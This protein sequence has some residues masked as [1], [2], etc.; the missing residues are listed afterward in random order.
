MATA[1]STALAA[2][3]RSWRAD[4]VL[5]VRQAL[6]ASPDGWQ[7]ATLR[8]LHRTGRASASACH[9]PGKSAT[10]AWAIWWV[11][12]C[13]SDP[14]VLTTA[15]TQHQLRDVLWSEVAKWGA[16]LPAGIRALFDVGTER[17]ALKARP[18]TWWAVARVARPEQPE[19]LAGVHADTVLVVIDEASGVHDAIWETLEG[20]LTGPRCWILAI[21]NPTRRD[22]EF[23][24]IHG[25]ADS[26]WARHRVM[27]A[28]AHDGSPLPA[29]V[30]TSE[31]VGANYEDKMR[32]RYGVESNVY[33]VRVLGLPP[34]SNDD[35]TIPT[36]WVEAAAVRPV[37]LDLDACPMIGVDVARFG[38]DDSALV[39]R[40]GTAILHVET[41]HGHDIAETTGRVVAYAKGVESRMVEREASIKRA[42]PPVLWI[43][44]DTTGLGAGVADNLRAYLNGEGKGRPW[45]VL[46]VDAGSAS[47]DDEC[48][49]LRDA[50]WW[51]TREW[52]REAAPSISPDVP[53][54]EREQLVA[55]LGAPTYKFTPAG[56]VHVEPKEK[57][58]DRGVASPNAADAL[59]HTFKVDARQPERRKPGTWRDKQAPRKGATWEWGTA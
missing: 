53:Q 51:R 52:F 17:I 19:S 59:I 58:K 25:G 18:E 55:E 49:R 36:E 46:D 41:W 21:G 35:Q 16:R 20:A 7:I 5:F 6:R 23:Y 24:R 27:A 44:V 33:R 45:F 4:P 28:A 12:V 32:L 50:L 54:Q 11:L 9:G 34:K 37:V 42:A 3:L 1:R 14:R 8:D 31:R 47:P 39:E 26:R 13:W 56:V 57:L 2:R 38:S 15:P 22:G 10:A 40:H 30:W 43:C 29:G 48:L